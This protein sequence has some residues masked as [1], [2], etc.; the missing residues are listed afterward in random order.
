MFSDRL[1]V[2]GKT[3]GSVLPV[4]SSSIGCVIV[5]IAEEGAMLV[6]VL[7][8]L[9]TSEDREVKVAAMRHVPRVDR[10][11]SVKDVSTSSRDSVDREKFSAKGT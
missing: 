10:K 9:I 8:L 2:V 5:S 7:V 6:I 4:S 1:E 11:E 3:E